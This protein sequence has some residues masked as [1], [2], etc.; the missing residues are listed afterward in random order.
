VHK[1]RHRDSV[2]D[3][4]HTPQSLQTTLNPAQEAVAVAL[5]KTLLV[6]LDDLLAVVREV[7]NPDTSR[8]GLDRCLRRHGA[9][10]MRALTA[11][12]PWSKHGAFKAYKPGYL[13]VDVKYLP[14]MAEETSR[15]YLFVAIDL[16]TR[17]VVIRNYK[18]KTAANDRRFLRDLE[19]ACPMRIRTIL[20]ERVI[21]G[22]IGS[23]PM[24]SGKESTDRLFG[25]RKRNPTGKHEFDQLCTDHSPLSFGPMARHGSSSST[26]LLRHS[27]RKPTAWSSDSMAASRRCCKA[28]TAVRDKSWKP[29][30]IAT[31]G[32]TT[33]SFRS[34]PWAAKRPCRR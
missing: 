1:W 3:R 18:S 15:R 12:E 17:W 9:G 2:H 34:P 31:S 13:H 23:S 30:C 14:Q 32:S 33:R 10:N 7:L 21:E 28:T 4:S 22:A 20:T 16:A 11:R 26:A 24:A 25:L 8:S 5:R 19:K 27:T 29:R 6:S